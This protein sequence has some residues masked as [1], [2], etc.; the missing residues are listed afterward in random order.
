MIK[1]Y[2]SSDEVNALIKNEDLV[3]ALFSDLGCNVCLSIT[4]DLEEMSEAYEKSHFISADVETIKTLVG[5]YGVFVYP[6]V[7]VF[8]QGKEA[9]R[10]ERV[11]SIGDIEASVSRYNDLLF[12]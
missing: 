6:T 3:V 5:E 4:P 7:I 10:F 11:F 1:N 8:T 9:I 2:T 12:G